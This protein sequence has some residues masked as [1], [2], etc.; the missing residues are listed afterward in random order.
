VGPTHQIEGEEGEGNGSGGWLARP[1]AVSVAGLVWLPEA[2][3]IFFDFL[4]FLFS[5]SF[6]TILF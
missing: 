5:F 2:F 1:Q 3:F 6:E 4:L